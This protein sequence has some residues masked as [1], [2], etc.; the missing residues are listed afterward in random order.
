MQLDVAEEDFIEEFWDGDVKRKFVTTERLR[1]HIHQ[2]K[3]AHE[4]AKANPNELA[5]RRRRTV[6]ALSISYK[7]RLGRD[8]RI[9]QLL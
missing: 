8:L 7:A 1:D 5:D 9:S 3:A 6:E 2:W 4:N